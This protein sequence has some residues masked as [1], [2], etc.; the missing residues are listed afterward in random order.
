MA[1][2]PYLV[3]NGNCRDAVEFYAEAF[4][5]EK[6][7]IMLMG[8][9]P[10]SEEY[11]IPEEAKNLVMHTSLNIAGQHLMFS[12]T[13][14]GSPV[15]IGQNIT[16]AYVSED[17]EAIQALYDKLSVGGNVVMPLQPTF[18]SELYGQVTDRFGIQWQFNY[19]QPAEE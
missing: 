9:N 1:I 18:W 8:D 17:K 12:D 10:Q 15:T 6:N 3:F 14:P 5:V 7:P 11:P 13:F 19:E 4:G 16:L 2:H